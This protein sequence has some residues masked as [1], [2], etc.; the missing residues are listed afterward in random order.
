[1]PVTIRRRE[2]IATIGGAA[3]WP[4]AARAQQPAMPVI[5]FLCT[6]LPSEYEDALVAF[7]QGLS[8]A[9]YVEHRNIGIEYRWAEDRYDRLPPLAADLVRRRVVVIATAGGGIAAMAARTATATIPVVFTIGS[10]PIRAGLVASIN[11]PGGNVTG[12]TMIGGDLFP[13]RLELLRELIPKAAG[14]AVPVNP[15]DPFARPETH[16]MEQAAIVLGVQ[17]HFL[18]AATDIELETAFATLLQRRADGLVVGNDGFFFGRRGKIIALAGRHAVPTV[19][20]W[21]EF[22]VAGGLL[23]YGSSRT[24]AYR[25]VGT[26]TAR[27]LKGEKPANLPV[28]QPTKFEIA[29]NLKTAKAFGLEVP[30]LL[31]ARADDVIE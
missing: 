21:K 5:G 3:A 8:D 28:L 11:R 6:G 4:L 25:L 13:K 23:S 1:M 27:I 14:I 26:Y 16:D 22:V 15:G 20:P 10:D 17:L 29:I 7:Q 31:L 19:Y 12:V 30:P 2:L 18:N 9:G 24:E